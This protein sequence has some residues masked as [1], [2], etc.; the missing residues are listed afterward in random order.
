MKKRNLVGNPSILILLTKFYGRDIA[1]NNYMSKNNIL[2]HLY[3]YIY[4]NIF[5]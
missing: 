5:M 1:L 4:I 3:G 2:V